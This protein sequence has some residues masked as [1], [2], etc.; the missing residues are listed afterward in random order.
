[1][2]TSEHWVG[3]HGKGA[4][5]ALATYQ[6]TVAVPG[7]RTVYRASFDFGFALPTEDSSVV[8]DSGAA[9]LR[10]TF[11]ALDLAVPASSI[12]SGSPPVVTLDGPREVRRVA[13]TSGNFNGKHVQ[14]FRLD[15]QR[16]ASDATVSAAVGSGRAASGF[17]GFTDTRF[18]IAVQEGGPQKSDLAD[19][20]VR[21]AATGVRLGLADPDDPG[22]VTF[23][24]PTPDQTGTSVSA[25]PA[26]GQ[27]L[28]DYLA[29]KAGD[30]SPTAR[31]V[32]QGDQPCTF[33]LTAFDTGAS[34]AVDGFAA[35]ALVAGDLLDEQALA[36]R[37]AAGADPVSALLRGA[38]GK[39]ALL[40][41]LN[42]VVAGGSIFDAQRFDGVKL[43]PQ[44]QAAL[45]GGDPARV[46]RLL[47]QDAY[48]DAVAAPAAKR[49]L[50]FGGGKVEAQSLAVRLPAGATVSKATVETQESLQTDRA[51]AAAPSAPPAGSGVHIG[52]DGTAAVG[53]PVAAAVSATGVSLPLVALATGTEVSVELQEDFQGAPSGKRLAAGTAKLAVPG[54]VEHATV[55][56]DPIVLPAGTVW[57]ALRAA[58]G[59][60]VWLAAPAEAD[61]LRVRRTTDGGGTTETVLPGLAP[62]FAL[63]SRS[64]DATG[65]AATSLAVGA[66]TVAARRDGSRSTFDLAG[67]LQG[68]DGT[69]ALTFT[70][71][72]AGTITVYPP[73][74]EYEV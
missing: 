36:A 4:A 26:F 38:I 43:S 61:G 17:G 21:G 24:W 51:A 13:F 55:F 33:V 63:F 5:H 62:D 35:P 73:H 25:D 14:L 59:E 3:A 22:D 58:R 31:V 16:R 65:A 52:S 8:I 30:P 42:A 37:I 70:S 74:V 45:T 11:Q 67:A 9:R 57:L 10:G 56:F 39:A 54:A 66:T 15:Q 71:A 7:P 41:G 12:S 18:A 40:D 49:V 34:F 64:G 44:T 19:V 2:K 72:V 48:P 68:V 53:V 27:A 46:N 23:F 47:L 29:G 6:V 28:A 69:V 32:I 20:T 50:R 60:A 1:M